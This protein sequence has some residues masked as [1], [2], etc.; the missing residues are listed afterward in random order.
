MSDL[1]SEE[2]KYDPTRF[3]EIS[4][5]YQ[6]IVRSLMDY[7]ADNIPAGIQLEELKKFKE[8]YLDSAF[9]CRYRECPRYSD[10]FKSS[11][12]RDDHERLHTKPLRCA[13]PSCDFFARGFTSK[14][15]LNKHNRKYHPLPDEVDPPDFEPGKEQEPDRIPTP[16]PQPQAPAPARR[17]ATPVRRSPE[18]EPARTVRQAPKPRAER[19][20]RAKKGL[21]VHHCDLCPKVCLLLHTFDPGANAARSSH[22]M[23]DSSMPLFPI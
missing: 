1:K 23:K 11:A 7:T 14:T 10:G 2:L 18:P 3:S 22:E 21:P 4:Q 5:H 12:E 8:I 9:I 20:S 6:E 17:A 19:V 16:P 13:D 15:G